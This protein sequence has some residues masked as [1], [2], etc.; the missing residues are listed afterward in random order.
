MPATARI[1]A[2]AAAHWASFFQCGFF[3]CDDGTNLSRF[4]GHSSMFDGERVTLGCLQPL[5]N[6]APVLALVQ[7]PSCTK[8][9]FAVSIPES[10][11][12]RAPQ[13]PFSFAAWYLRHHKGK[14][15]CQSIK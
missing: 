5:V 7:P 13:F 15:S 8:A 3:Q 1:S 14:T 2:K 12:L 9:A 6:L 11:T 10:L 4:T